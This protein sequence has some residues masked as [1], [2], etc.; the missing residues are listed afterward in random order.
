MTKIGLS[1]RKSPLTWAYTQN[2]R[3]VLTV[4]VTGFTLNPRLA[5]FIRDTLGPAATP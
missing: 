4:G 2:Q 5:R 1:T 3:A